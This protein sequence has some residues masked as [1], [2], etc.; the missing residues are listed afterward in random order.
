MWPE[1]VVATVILPAKHNMFLLSCALRLCR[2]LPLLLGLLTL[3]RRR[4]AWR[5]LSTARLLTRSMIMTPT[6]VSKGTEKSFIT[7]TASTTCSSDTANH[8]LGSM[9]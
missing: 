6:M 1:V 8:P 4:R 7:S 2:D 5:G 3:R 9:W